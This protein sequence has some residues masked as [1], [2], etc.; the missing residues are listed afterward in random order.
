M[1]T[2]LI[3]MPDWMRGREPRTIIWD[4]EAWSDPLKVVQIY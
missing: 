3:T 1:A 2:H 4:D